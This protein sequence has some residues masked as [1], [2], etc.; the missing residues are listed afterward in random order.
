[1]GGLSAARRFG[2]ARFLATACIA[3]ALAGT[4]AAETGAAETALPAGFQET[5]VFSGLTTP[6]AI[7]FAADGRV[8]VAE[9]GGRIK[10]FDGLSDSSP[11]SLPICRRTCTTSGTGGC[12]DFALDPAFTTG[13]P[14]VYVLYTYDAPIGGSAPTWGDACPSPPGA[15]GDGCVVSAPPLAADCLGQLH[16]RPGERPDQRLV[17][18]VPEPLDRLARLRLRRGA[19]RLGWRWRELQLHRL[20]AGRQPAEPLWRSAGRGRAMHYRR[21]APR[22][23]RCAARICARHR[24]RRRSTARSCG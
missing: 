7:E 2:T 18:A 17:S 15:T 14:Y 10:V 4:G 24:I 16:D 9:K 11:D 1:M 3:L 23:G 5:T 8:F 12:S 21:R 19:V 6:M 22:E 13:R 20:G